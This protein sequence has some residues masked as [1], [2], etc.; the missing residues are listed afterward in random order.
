MSAQGPKAKLMGLG[1][2]LLPLILVKG[3][4][5]W[6]GQSPEGADASVVATATVDSGVIES[7]TPEWS[8]EQ[9]AAAHRVAELREVPFDESPL[10]HPRKNTD[11]S[12]IE[13]PERPKTITPPDVSVRIILHSRHGDVALIGHNRYRVG[14]AIGQ[15]GWFVEAID[16]VSRSVLIVH[17]PSGEKATLVVPMPRS[18]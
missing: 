8:S 11:I 9:I 13:A 6:V 3:T 14:D 2:F 5:I 10:L 1:V 17:R 18:R 12:P 4:A 15:D 7:F 16:A